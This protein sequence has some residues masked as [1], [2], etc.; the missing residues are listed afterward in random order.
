[1]TDDLDRLRLL[2]AVS[3]TGS[4]AAAAREAGF[5]ASAV[6]QQ[7]ATLERRVGASL[8]ERSNRGVT[9]TPAGASLS[10]HAASLLDGLDAGIA[11]A[12]RVAGARPSSP[13]R[14]AAFPT[15]V[16]ALLLPV[17]VDGA[18]DLPPVTLVHREPDAAL[19][20]LLDRTVDLAV[21]DSY[22]D[23]HDLPAG[24]DA[25]H[26]A[27]DVLHLLVPGPLVGQG[28][29]DLRDVGW[30]L[31]TPGSNLGVA[32]RTL[33]RAAGFEPRTL[34]ETDDHTL[35]LT[36]AGAMGA[37]T[38]QPGLATADRRRDD[39]LA[40]SPEPLGVTRE[41]MV[42]RRRLARPDPSLATVVSAL[43]ARRLSPAA[44]G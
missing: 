25:E 6:S 7:L 29:A 27:T 23:A 4:I 14:I 38:F 42:V 24:V 37:A 36:I 9:M 10:A 20:A 8:L 11:E 41:V 16:T 34:A 19:E 40:V 17:L 21:I 15:A 39:G 2:H 26:L 32:G 35:A 31:G 1:M 30:V 5:T 28:L 18:A 12:V 13:V 44:T 43:R 3:R 22:G 33:C